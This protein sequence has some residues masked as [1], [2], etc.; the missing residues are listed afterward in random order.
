M[1]KIWATGSTKFLLLRQ[2]GYPRRTRGFPSHDCS[3]FGFIVA[4]FIK[5]WR[6]SMQVKCQR[7]MLRVTYWSCRGLFKNVACEQDRNCLFLSWKEKCDKSNFMHFRRGPR[8]WRNDAW[9][10]VGPSILTWKE[11]YAEH[12]WKPVTRNSH[13]R[14][15]K[16]TSVYRTFVSLSS[17]W[18]RQA[19]HARRYARLQMIILRK[20]LFRMSLRVLW[21]QLDA[22]GTKMAP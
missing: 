8:L 20:I 3:W 11:S 17:S 16:S 6:V 1:S 13:P 5:F 9:Q 21:C 19:Q 15:T 10:I 18:S 2:P 14:R 7:V 22:T 4:G 12:L